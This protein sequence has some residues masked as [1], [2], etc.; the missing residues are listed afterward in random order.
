LLATHQEPIISVE[1]E[2]LI[3]VF[4]QPVRAL[5]WAVLNGG[6]AYV[7]GLVNHHVAKGDK[8]FAADPRKWL[9]AKVRRR[10]LRGK[11]VGMA[12]AVEM[13]SL[14]TASLASE[15]VEVRCFATVGHGNAL[16]AG[17]CS[18][19]ASKR[20][21]IAPHTINM[22]LL[23]R[24]GLS[25]KAMVEAVQIATEGRVRA[26]YEGGIRSSRSG[27]P[28]TGTGT[29]CIAVISLDGAEAPYCGKHTKL[30][31][32]IGLASYTTVKK[33]LAAGE[34]AAAIERPG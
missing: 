17:D 25:E 30:G 33:G 15:G 27:L 5:S 7:D 8:A 18:S 4:R 14:A 10:R 1:R 22:I 26:L 13:R 21:A 11:V 12:T 23:V 29:D 6:F 20:E 31:E 9:E 3:L 32:L 34:A 28:A 24:P 16:A 19:P 2:A